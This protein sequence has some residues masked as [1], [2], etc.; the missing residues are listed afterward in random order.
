MYYHV[1]KDNVQKRVSKTSLTGK[2]IFEENYKGLRR[3]GDYFKVSNSI[4]TLYNKAFVFEAKEEDDSFYYL[5]GGIVEKEIVFDAVS[6]KSEKKFQNTQKRDKI[7]FPYKFRDKKVS[8]YE[9]SEFKSQFPECYSYLKSH[10]ERLLKRKSSEG[11]QWFEYGRIQAISNV[12]VDKLIIS[13]VITNNV[14]VY[15]V[16]CKSVPYAGMYI[17]ALKMMSWN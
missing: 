17:R 4:A 10:K 9:E 5:D 3:F 16:G 15:T 13:V 7:I 8:S 11:V 6:I 12:F 14:Q 1:R 2:W